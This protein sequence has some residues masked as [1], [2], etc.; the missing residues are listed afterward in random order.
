M[1]KFVISMLAVLAL[2]SSINAAVVVPADQ[3]AFGESIAE[4][5]DSFNR[6]SAKALKKMPDKQFDA[7]V[8]NGAIGQL[9]A[10]MSLID[11]LD[12]GMEAMGGG[13][14]KAKMREFIQN[15]YGISKDL[16]D[17]EFFGAIEKFTAPQLQTIN[18]E[19]I[20][21]IAKLFEQQ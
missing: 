9:E 6:M 8:Y 3:S 18:E 14:I 7:M 2:S 21:R 15:A 13:G 1:K 12:K 20:Y 16:D 11:T 4:I 17:D 10:T 19:L 5:Q